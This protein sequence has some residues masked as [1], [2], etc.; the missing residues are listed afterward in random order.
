MPLSLSLSLFLSLSLSLSIMTRVH[1][2]GDA[3]FSSDCID[4]TLHR[5]SRVTKIRHAT[6]T[7]LAV[8]LLSLSEEEG[9]FLLELEAAT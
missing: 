4:L 9:T 7:Q 1:D 2:V 5:R 6:L 3:P 8:Q